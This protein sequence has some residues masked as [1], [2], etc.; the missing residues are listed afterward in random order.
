MNFKDDLNNLI[1]LID[2]TSKE[3]ATVSNISQSV[4]SRYRNGERV[5]KAN[6]SQFNSLVEGLTNL[7]HDK[8]VK[9]NKSKLRKN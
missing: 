2:C 5:P 6:S 4:I 8:K 1:E 3:I 9:L 7:A